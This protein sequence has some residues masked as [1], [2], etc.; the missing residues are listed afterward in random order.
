ML[1]AALGDR[2]CAEPN[3]T[4]PHHPGP[5]VCSIPS[6]RDLPRIQSHCFPTARDPSVP[7][8]SSCGVPSLLFPPAARPQ[9]THQGPR[10]AHV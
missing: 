6:L 3:T 7:A 8:H 4:L 1:G 10:Q 2:E 9:R 5:H